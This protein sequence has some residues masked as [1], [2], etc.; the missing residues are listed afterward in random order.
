MNCSP[1]IGKTCYLHRF[2]IKPKFTTTPNDFGGGRFFKLLSSANDFGLLTTKKLPNLAVMSFFI[3]LGEIG[4][5]V[6][7]PIKFV[8]NEADCDLHRLRNF[9]ATLFADVLQIRQTFLA[10]DYTNQENSYFIVPV[11]NNKINWQ[12]VDAFQTIPEFEQ[13]PE[14]KRLGMKFREE[15]YLFKVVSPVPLIWTTTTSLFTRN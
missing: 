2:S 1:V 6:L 15:D 5:E 11:T 9:H 14:D 13:L 4:V 10:Y 7:A 3:T 12:L 8:L